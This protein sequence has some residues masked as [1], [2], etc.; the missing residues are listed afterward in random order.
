VPEDE[1]REV[2]QA[3]AAIEQSKGRDRNELLMQ[4]GASSAFIAFACE[5]ALQ[6]C[7]ARVSLSV[8]EYEEIRKVATHFVVAPMHWI[9]A[10][11][12]VV[13]ETA[14]YQVVE[15]IETAAIVATKLAPRDRRAASAR[16]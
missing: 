12:R 5:C 8:D 15:K 3:H 16:S 6:S 1:Q 4:T 9:P 10:V 11:E 2:R 7:E 13:R 14:R